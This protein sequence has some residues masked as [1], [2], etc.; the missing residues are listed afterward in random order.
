[1]D[2][3]ECKSDGAWASAECAGPSKQ[4]S[5]L[6]FWAETK[7]NLVQPSTVFT[8]NASFMT[9]KVLT[10]FKTSSQI[11]LLQSHQ[12]MSHSN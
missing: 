3:Q 1:M 2:G 12:G 4:Q 10:F 9:L 7:R 5:I 11:R 8:K 6:G